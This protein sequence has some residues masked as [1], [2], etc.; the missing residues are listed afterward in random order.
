MLPPRPALAA[1]REGGSMSS[2]RVVFVADD[3]RLADALGGQLRRHLGRPPLTCRFDGVRDHLGPETDGLLLL[4]AF[5]PAGAEE[6][7]ALVRE[8]ALRKLPPILVLVEG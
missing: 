2:Q 6:A 7:L 1:A 4:A 3:P 5:T 8:I